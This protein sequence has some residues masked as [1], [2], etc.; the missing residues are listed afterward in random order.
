MRIIAGEL[1]GHKLL[2]PTGKH[3][4]R[5]ITGMA[6]KSLFQILSPELPGASVLDLYCGTGTLGLEALS[7]GAK[8]CYFAE[9]N[10]GAVDRLRRNVQK[11]GV[12]DR[13]VIWAGDVENRLNSL[14]GELD[15]EIDV[16]FIDPPYDRARKWNWDAAERELFHPIS[17]RLTR[18]GL[19][20]LRTPADLSVPRSLSGLATHRTKRYARMLVTI[21]RPQGS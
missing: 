3:R 13:S 7:R 14:L 20:V 17:S 8:R 6:R 19:M 16:A 11:L 5:P 21:Y 2:G 1:K 4:T 9:R 15:E 12:T 10:R 18:G